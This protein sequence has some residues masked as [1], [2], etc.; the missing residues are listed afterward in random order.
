VRRDQ[1]ADLASGQRTHLV[2][3]EARTS[4][5][6]PAGYPVETWT[7]VAKVWASRR[8]RTGEEMFRS[9]QPIAAQRVQWTVAY[10]EDLDPE[11]SSVPPTWRIVDHC[12]VYDVLHAYVLGER[13]G[14]VLLTEARTQALA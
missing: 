13:A 10:D 4:V 6:S 5:T 11:R 9:G 7:A 14:I 1:A 2:C 12:R 3:L 8:D